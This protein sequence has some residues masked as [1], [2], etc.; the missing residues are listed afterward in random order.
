V[1]EHSNQAPEPMSLE[2]GHFV[3]P[4]LEDLNAVFDEYDFI[5]VIGKGG[6]GT[7]YEAV[8]KSINRPVAI[9]ILQKVDAVEELRFAERFEREVHVLAQMSHANIVTVYSFGKT[10]DGQLFFAMEYV[11]GTDL[12]RMIQQG[13]LDTGRIFKWVAQICDALFYAHSMG[14]VHRDIKPGNILITEKGDVK[15]ADFGLAKL[16]GGGITDEHTRLTGTNL[17]MG[18]PDYVAPEVLETG[19][20]V[21]HRVDIYAMGVVLYE[22][23]TGK[24]PRGA[25]KPPS[26]LVTGLNKGFDEIILKAMDPDQNLRYSDANA[27]CKS[28]LAVRDEPV[29]AEFASPQQQAKILTQAATPRKMVVTPPASEKKSAKTS[30]PRGIHTKKKTA[31]VKKA[32][33]KTSNIGI[34]IG[35]VVIIAIL[36]TVL[37]LR[38]IK[39]APVVVAPGGSKAVDI[40]KV[41]SVVGSKHLDAAHWILSKGGSLQ[42]RVLGHGIQSVTTDVELPKGDF[43]ILTFSIS[44]QSVASEE[45]AVFKEVDTLT[46]I[47]FVQVN[48]DD[49]GLAHL[50]RSPLLNSITIIDCGVT[51]SGLAKFTD[52]SI[53]YNFIAAKSPFSDDGMK[54]L[55]RS[56]YLN[57]VDLDGTKIT[58]IG[59]AHLANKETIVRLDISGT[60]VTSAGLDQLRGLTILQLIEVR[61]CSNISEASRIAFLKAHPSCKMDPPLKSAPTSL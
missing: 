59:L 31:V 35:L 15:I 49:V 8:Q 10:T 1:E 12:Y 41:A 47:G 50:G 11:Q 48:I 42:A 43:K 25:F 39:Q 19:S 7:V 53:I 22:M 28:L 61:D 40:E 51:G 6:M 46:S 5:R 37:I 16:T 24:V 4:E 9:K 21:D 26:S 29:M 57:N 55:G 32:P 3:S 2:T 13:G 54:N 44:N 18:S 23:L 33:V 27:L 34:V 60:A 45:L 56:Y 20:N 38:N 30:T 36:L 52:P 14:V 17:A 58:D